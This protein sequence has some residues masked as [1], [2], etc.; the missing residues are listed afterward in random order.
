LILSFF[1]IYKKEL[2]KGAMLDFVNLQ[3]LAKGAMLDFVNLQEL[4][5]GRERC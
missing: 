5:K 4:A 1:S 3:E 2:A